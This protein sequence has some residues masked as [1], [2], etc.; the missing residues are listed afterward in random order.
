MAFSVHWFQFITFL[1]SVQ[2]WY[3]YT[4]NFQEKQHN[5]DNFL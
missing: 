4:K 5:N 3:K 2:L 1:V